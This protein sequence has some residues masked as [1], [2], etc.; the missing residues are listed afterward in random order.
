MQ[1]LEIFERENLVAQS[2]EKGNYLKSRLEE[3]RAHPTVGA[4]R[5]RG[6]YC[7]LDM[8]KN[9]ETRESWGKSN[10]TNRLGELLLERGLV[11]R[12]WDVLHFAPPLVATREEIDPMVEI[13]DDSLTV[14]EREFAADIVA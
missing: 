10:F 7:G 3:L 6:L 14:A 2:A 13:A 8:V 12:A 11:T 1:N 4:V 5:G 9:K